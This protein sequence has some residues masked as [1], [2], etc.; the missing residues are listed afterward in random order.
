MSIKIESI[1]PLMNFYDLVFLFF[2]SSSCLY[3]PF[4]ASFHQLIL[5]SDCWRQYQM[6]NVSVQ[7]SDR[8]HVVSLIGRKLSNLVN[9]NM[10]GFLQRG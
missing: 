7:V 9:M 10:T 6:E 8:Y 4:I 3:F 1:S 5:G 2:M